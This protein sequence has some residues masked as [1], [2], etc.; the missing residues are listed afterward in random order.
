M[1]YVN[2]QRHGRS[3]NKFRK[4]QIPK[5]AD[6]KLHSNLRT[7]GSW[8][9]FETD[10]HEIHSLKYYLGK[11]KVLEATQ[12]GSGSETQDFSLQICGFAICGLGHRGNLRIIHYKFADLRL[13][14]WHTSELCDLR[15][16]N[17]NL[18][19]HL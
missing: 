7:F 2:A 8:D 18:R 9:S 16:N 5:F 14:D 12:R 3:A 6:S 10:L 11:E 4:S 15:T 19:A 17:K 1:L 13:A